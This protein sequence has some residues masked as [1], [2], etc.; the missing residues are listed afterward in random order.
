MHHD[1]ETITNVAHPDAN[2]IFGATIDDG[3]GDQ[4][5]VTV[6]AAGFDKMGDG[7]QDR[8]ARA[9]APPREHESAPAILQDEDEEDVFKPAP[10]V[11]VTESEEDLDIPDFLKS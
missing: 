8:I 7:R 2:I 9:A 4:V 11:I 5:R 3:L 6:I 10:A 1:A